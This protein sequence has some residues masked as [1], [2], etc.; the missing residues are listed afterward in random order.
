MRKWG[1]SGSVRYSAA[2]VKKATDFPLPV[3]PMTQT[4]GAGGP[5]RAR[6]KGSYWRGRPVCASRPQTG[7]APMSSRFPTAGQLNASVDVSQE[8]G[9]Q[10]GRAPPG[11]CCWKARAW[12]SSS[13]R[14]CS[15]RA[16]SLPVTWRH[17][18]SHASRE[19]PSQVTTTVTA[20]RRVVPSERACCTRSTSRTAFF[21]SRPGIVPRR[22]FRSSVA[23]CPVSARVSLRPAPKGLYGVQVRLRRTVPW[24]SGP[25][26]HSSREASQPDQPGATRAGLSWTSRERVQRSPTA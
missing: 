17:T 4:W 11:V 22:A 14:Q 7:P 24:A 20:S 15:S 12:R 3:G 16:W 8:S 9:C 23:W 18:A 26:S 1:G 5:P 2:T 13:G 6:S 25:P 10:I 21:T 19:G